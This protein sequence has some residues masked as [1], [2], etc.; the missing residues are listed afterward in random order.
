MEDIMKTQSRLMDTV[1]SSY[2]VLVIA[3]L[4]VFLTVLLGI[5]WLSDTALRSPWGRM[6][7]AIRDNEVSAEAMGKDVTRRHLQV[8]WHR[9]AVHVDAKRVSGLSDDGGDST[10]TSCNFSPVNSGSLWNSLMD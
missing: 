3:L 9:Y 5:L 8:L 10:N 4:G 1:K 6:M 2:L 7:R